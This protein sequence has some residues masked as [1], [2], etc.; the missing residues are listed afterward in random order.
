[1]LVDSTRLRT[2]VCVCILQK[3]TYNTRIG[4]NSNSMNS[5]VSEVSS[6]NNSS[7]YTAQHVVKLSE[8]EH[9]R[10]RPLMYV[11]SVDNPMPLLSEV[12][13]NALDEVLNMRGKQQIHVTLDYTKNEYRV[14]D[15]GRG[16]PW[17]KNRQTGLPA[18]VLVASSLFSGAKFAK[19]LDGSIYKISAGLHGV[20]LSVVNFL[21]SQMVITSRRDGMVATAVFNGG[22]H[23]SLNIIPM[24]NSTSSTST[25][26][27]GTEVCFIPS[28]TIFTDIR[29]PEDQV[30]EYLKYILLDPTVHK[31]LSIVLTVVDLDGTTRSETIES[32]IRNLAIFKDSKHSIS[33]MFTSEEDQHGEELYVEFTYTN[34]RQLAECGLV[35]LK[36][37]NT[38]THI[39]WFKS[40]LFDA[41]ED[42][43]Q[44]HKIK[45]TR[46]DMGYG[47]KIFCSAKIV[48]V[49]YQGQAKTS[50]K[51]S[52]SYFKQKFGHCVPK[53]VESINKGKNMVFLKAA[54]ESIESFKQRSS[55]SKLIET[56][57]GRNEDKSIS[58]VTRGLADVD[59]LYDCLKPGKDGT[60]LY[61]VEGASAG[62]T[63][64]QIRDHNKH[65]VLLL[66]GKTI[67][68]IAQED[69]TKIFNNRE[70]VAILKAIGVE[71]LVIN[72]L[73]GKNKASQY[74]STDLAGN[75]LDKL[76]RYEKVVLTQDADEEGQHL[77]LLVMSILAKFIPQ[78]F[79]G[80][81]IYVADMPL[82]MFFEYTKDA[83]SK[84]GAGVK[85]IPVH[86]HKEAQ[87][88]LK[89][90][91][92][93]PNKYKFTRY[94]G[95]GEMDPLE[96]Q[97][98]CINQE[99]RRL[100][101]L[102]PS[103]DELCFFASIMKNTEAKKQLLDSLLE[104]HRKHH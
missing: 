101:P 19:S 77:T 49:E 1:M 30:R 38:G 94:K 92:D 9:V 85:M 91:Q 21:S 83:S 35:N 47:L 95:L 71:K 4:G 63:L 32:D 3:K 57:L 102:I 50:L 64:L 5:I 60:E 72:S 103:D 20:G 62:G 90:C 88:W 18:I 52:V 104:K 43:C 11:D 46:Y 26:H 61:I 22:L 31:K 73:N 76:I 75:Q 66:R 58:N 96:F 14:L 40:L 39:S 15:T 81:Y 67:N 6:N 2:L 97:M 24:S 34:D 29:I 89:Y 41:L 70:V 37:V 54:M 16:I 48:N 79:I 33:F 98:S 36:P 87:K 82:Y 65:G 45:I 69:H 74:T 8:I 84:N 86:T 68:A 12:I 59:N 23:T 99:T 56:L 53:F 25:V 51:T 93:Y 42:M 17:Q 13:D 78:L 100:I 55:Q 44:K 80:G 28:E 10:L 7:A 27:K